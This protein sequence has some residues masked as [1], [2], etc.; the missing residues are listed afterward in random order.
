[1]SKVY[2]LELKLVVVVIALFLD[3]IRNGIR[4]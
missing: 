3:L 4:L 1:M 2:F